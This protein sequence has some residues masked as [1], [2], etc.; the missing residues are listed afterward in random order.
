MFYPVFF[1]TEV[2]GTKVTWSKDGQVI[3]DGDRIEIIHEDNAHSL[4]IME[5]ELEDCG[6]YSI[7]VGNPVGQ[8]EENVNVSVTFPKETSEND[9]TA[10]SADILAEPTDENEIEQAEV[11]QTVSLPHFS[12]K[13]EAI[14]VKE[15]ETILIVFSL[16]KGINRSIAY[17]FTGSA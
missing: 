9:Q 6:K 17:A 11:E 8:V 2:A 7:C 5:S 10:A 13:P 4:Q 14:C 1:L 15:G 3:K 16:D 12:K